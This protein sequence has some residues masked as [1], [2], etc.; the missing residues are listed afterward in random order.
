MFISNNQKPDD[1]ISRLGKEVDRFMR[2]DADLPT[3]WVRS[4][5]HFGNSTAFDRWYRDW[6]YKFL[7]NED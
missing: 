6:F 5:S 7:T 2:E 4:E 1:I 3:T